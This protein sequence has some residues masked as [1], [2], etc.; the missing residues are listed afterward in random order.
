MALYAD[1]VP[2]E[3]EANGFTDWATCYKDKL[4]DKLT[5]DA[6]D[7]KKKMAQDILKFMEKGGIDFIKQL[8]TDY[9]CA[10]ICDVP[11]FYITKN[12]SEGQPKKECF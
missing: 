4:K 7:K 12:I 3:W 10:S 2:F 9:Q 11:L 1:V 6:D 5:E 8:E